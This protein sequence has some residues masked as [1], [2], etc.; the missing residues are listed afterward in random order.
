MNLDTGPE[1]GGMRP[2]HTQGC[3]P[4]AVPGVVGP[5]GTPV[6]MAAPY[7]S[8]PPPSLW[9][10]QH[11][12]QHS[13]PMNM[14]QMNNG[15]GMHGG[16]LSP[17]GLPG[18]PGGAPGGMANPTM[19]QPMGGPM[20]PMSPTLP[21]PGSALNGGAPGD[22]QQ[23]QFTL[24]PAN[25]GI[26]QPG[27]RT[28]VRFLRPSGMQVSWYAMGPDGKP[29]YSPTPIETPGKYNFLQGARY[30][31]KLTNLG[32]PGVE[33]YPTLEVVP[34]NHKA[35]AFLAHSAVPLE[36]TEEDFKQVAEGNYVVKVIYLP[37]PQYQ[38][39]ASTGTDEILSTRLEPGQDPVQE[40]A[41]R[42]SVLLVV[43]MGNIDQEAPNTP[44]LSSPAPPTMPMGP[45][46]APKFGPTMPGM[47]TSPLQVPFWGMQPPPRPGFNGPPPGMVPNGMPPGMVPN[48]M[49]PGMVPN[50]MPPGMVPNGMPPGGLPPGLV[51]PGGPQG[52]LPP[53]SVPPGSIPPGA[54]P[55][56]VG[57]QP[58][59]NTSPN[60][61]P[62]GANGIPGSGT[63]FSS[64]PP[65]TEKTPTAPSLPGL[66]QPGTTP[67]TTTTTPPSLPPAITGGTTAPSTPPPTTTIPPAIPPALPK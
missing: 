30:R 10:A 32:R 2:L 14:V 16:V 60:L 35:E 52:A 49:P 12:M 29:M 67:G 23:A 46:Q 45:G 26:P 7:N 65:S 36:F 42:G 13:I 63:Q 51:P 24:N 20:S 56:T 33:L 21:A 31:L 28:Q 38:D 50:G 34:A 9:A 15:G 58:G 57:Q 44:P 8:A 17:A 53:G 61:P 55:P 39:V 43:R 66:D 22:I 25:A 27:M 62:L 59:L 3:G 18:F 40:A 1:S 19:S 64:P 48:G 54:L 5:Y 47:L 37:D 4:P 6:P 11:M 41:R